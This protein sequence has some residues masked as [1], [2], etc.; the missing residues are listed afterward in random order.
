MLGALVD[1]WAPILAEECNVFF[2][3]QQLWRERLRLIDVGLEAE[4]GS[5]WGQELIV[6]AIDVLINGKGVL[7]Q[8]TT[9]VLT[10]QVRHGADQLK[11]K[12]LRLNEDGRDDDAG[13]K[14]VR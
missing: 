1:S 5:K 8:A 2:L 4:R 11:K 3:I 14:G 12:V 6:E 9:C 10:E 7:G 13:L